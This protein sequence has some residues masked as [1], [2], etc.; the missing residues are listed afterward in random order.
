MKFSLNTWN[1]YRS[2][3]GILA[4]HI[5]SYKDKKGIIHLEKEIL[6]GYIGHITFILKECSNYMEKCGLKVP[7]PLWKYIPKDPTTHPSNVSFLYKHTMT[8]EQIV[9]YGPKF[10][11]SSLKEIKEKE[12]V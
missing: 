8:K 4:E 2:R 5:L 12:A 10:M 3:A 7:D 1:K 9:A 6:D 11:S